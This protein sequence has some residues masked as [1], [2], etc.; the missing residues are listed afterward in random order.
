MSMSKQAQTLSTVTATRNTERGAAL[1]TS[2]LVLSVLAAVSMTVL[3]VVTHESRIAGSDLQ[4][5]QTFYA[6]AAGIEKMTNDFSDLFTKTS[7]PTTTELNTISAGY[8]TEL[9][10]EGFSLH[11]NLVPDTNNDNHN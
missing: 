8:P 10:N 11:Q 2:L 6:A 4:R 3:A 7:R 5:T 1:A 9:L